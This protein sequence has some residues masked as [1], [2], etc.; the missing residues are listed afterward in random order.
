MCPWKISETRRKQKWL[1]WA[2]IL[3]VNMENGHIWKIKI[4]QRQKKTEKNRDHDGKLSII[5]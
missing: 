3:E 5:S 2:I 4:F 1:W